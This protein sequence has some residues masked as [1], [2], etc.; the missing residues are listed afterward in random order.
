[1]AR[2]RKATGATGELIARRYLEEQGFLS[3]DQN[4]RKSGG[5]LDLVMRDGEVLVFVEVK[6]RHGESHGT[7][8]SGI[9]L[10]QGEKL[11]QTAEWYLHDHVEFADLLWRIDLL[12]ITLDTMGSVQ[13]MTHIENA[14]QTG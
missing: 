12:A 3:L 11:M 6:T 10:R 4:W 14:V 13:R 7:A 9:S 2:D 5:E 1:M 8:E